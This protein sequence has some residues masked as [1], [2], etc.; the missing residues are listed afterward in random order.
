[1]KVR[2][3]K[4]VTLLLALV[5]VL[6]LAACGGGASTTGT[7]TTTSPPTTQAPSGGESTA[8]GGKP[9][10]NA[11]PDGTINLDT[12]ADYD[13]DYDYSQNPR[14]K[15]AYLTTEGGP[16]YAQSAKDYERIMSLYNC[17]WAG[18]LSANGDSNMYLTNLQNMIDQGVNGFVLDPDAELFVTIINLLKDYPDVKWMSQMAPPRDGSKDAGLPIGGNLVNPYVGFDN[19]DSGIQQTLKLIE[20][21]EEAYPDVPWEEVGFVAMAFSTSSALQERVIAAEQTWLEKTGSTD[22]FFVADVVA[23]GMTIQGAI[24]TVNPIISTNSGEYKHWLVMGLIDDFATAAASVIDQLGLSDTSCVTT[25]GGPSAYAQWD[26]GQQ[27]SFRFALASV[28]SMYSGRVMGALYA[29]LNDWA[30]PDTIWPSWIKWDDHGADG[31]N[32]A[33]LRLPVY[34]LTYDTYQHFLEWTDLYSNAN[35][36]DYD[37]E[38]DI[39]DYEPF[40]EVPAEYK[41]P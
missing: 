15:V 28:A 18:Y 40:M 8:G 17:E 4:M 21:K 2:T 20:W 16:L 22:N 31:H 33:Q 13:W 24:N 27:D 29:Y 11:N 14:Y 34:W 7:T 37:V 25:F 9:Y 3:K 23:N 1:M 6:T 41:A 19:A 5:M 26:E 30:T 32:F 10:P 39:N 35:E 12:I 38:V 36:Y